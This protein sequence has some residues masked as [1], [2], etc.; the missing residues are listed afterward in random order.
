MIKKLWIYL[1]PF[2][3]W[4]FLICFGLAWMITNG[5]CY[6]GLA[7]GIAWDINWLKAVCGGYAAFLY[8]P[9][10]VEKLVTIPLAIFF[11]RLLF[12]RDKK[13]NQQLLAMKEEAHKDWQ[14][15]KYKIWCMIHWNDI[16]KNRLTIIG[17]NVLEYYSVRMA[18]K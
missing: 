7:L 9:F 6:I 17:F 3:N 1:R 16:Y 10:T 8:F 13:L 12:R 14:T 18:K 2:L 11:Q 15:I 4:R 5:W